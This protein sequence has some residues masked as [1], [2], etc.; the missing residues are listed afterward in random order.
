[1]SIINESARLVMCLVILIFFFHM[2]LFFFCNKYFRK[3]FKIL[4][5]YL[6]VS[7]IVI[8]IFSIC[9]F[10]FSVADV[11][12]ISKVSNG[13]KV[14]QQVIYD[15]EI[16]IKNMDY[17]SY[18]HNFLGLIL[19]YLEISALNYFDIENKVEFFYEAQIIQILQ[20]VLSSFVPLIIIFISIIK[21]FKIKGKEELLIFLNLGWMILS[22]EKN[23]FTKK[24]NIILINNQ[25]KT[26][27]IEIDNI[28]E[29]KNLIKSFKY[30]WADVTLE[31]VP[32]F[33]K[34]IAVILRAEDQ[35]LAMRANELSLKYYILNANEEYY[36]KY[37][38]FLIEAK[39]TLSI[40]ES[41][42]TFD[43]F[44]HVLNLLKKNIQDV[45]KLNDHLKTEVTD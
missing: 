24:H 39:Y 18:K 17:H 1:M 28:I 15:N 14:S 38:N 9:Y 29:I 22:V 11:A 2:F 8:S 23:I 33:A 34:S 3:I 12:N 27:N 19:K 31:T 21:E 45:S 16:Y 4:I 42:I 41:D 20:K 26:K 37:Y 40:M 36:I 5:Q 7:S 35:N 43:D 25:G 10:V 6:I 32:F 30:S 44:D 13:E